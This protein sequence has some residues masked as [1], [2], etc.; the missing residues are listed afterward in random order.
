MFSTSARMLSAHLV[1]IIY[2]SVHDLSLERLEDNGAIPCNE[3]CLPTSWKDHPL[4]DI[5]NRNNRNDVAEL[6]RACTLY[7]CVQLAFKILQHPR[8]EIRRMQE[9]R[10]RE[11]FL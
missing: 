3:L 9:D 10:V 11:L 6:N 5:E 7:I 8:A 4:A 1:D 2:D